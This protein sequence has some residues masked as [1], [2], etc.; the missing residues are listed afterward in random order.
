MD[1]EHKY[2]EDLRDMMLTD[3][4]KA[5]IEELTGNSKVI[6]SV[7][8]A[9][10]EADL[11]FRKGQLNILTSLINLENSVEQAEAQAND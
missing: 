1:E 5:L 8:Q 7:L 10:D 3:G 11:Y 4:W 9:K 2:W 6:D